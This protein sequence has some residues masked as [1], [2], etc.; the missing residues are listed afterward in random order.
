M[1]IAGREYPDEIVK[2]AISMLQVQM[3]LADQHGD[4]HGHEMARLELEEIEAAIKAD[5]GTMERLG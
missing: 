1:V 5:E 3:L 2:K 4:R